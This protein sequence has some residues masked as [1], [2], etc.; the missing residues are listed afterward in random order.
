MRPTSSY[1]DW[2][3]RPSTT[4][5]RLSPSCRRRSDEADGISVYRAACVADPLDALAVF[6]P[7][8]RDRYGIVLLSVADLAALG[9]TVLPVPITAVPGHAVLP[10]LTITAATADRDV[11]RRVLADLAR[12]ANLRIVR[13]PKG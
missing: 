12:L 7:E 9:L 3:G 2:S 13:P 6:A 5:L 11:T 4:R 1:C 8:K 10:E